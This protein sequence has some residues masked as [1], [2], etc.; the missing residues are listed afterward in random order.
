MATPRNLALG[1]FAIHDITQIKQ[2]VQPVRPQPAPRRPTDHI[3]SH[4]AINGRL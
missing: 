3:A 2:T 4:P 1:L